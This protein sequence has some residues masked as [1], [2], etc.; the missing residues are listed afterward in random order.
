MVQLYVK[1]DTYS[2]ANA[3]L[4]WCRGCPAGTVP[5]LSR[6][7]R[8]PKEGDPD[9]ASF[10][11]GSGFPA[12]L[13]S[14]GGCGTRISPSVCCSNSPRRLARSFMRCSARPTGLLPWLC[15]H[16]SLASLGRVSSL[17]PTDL[18]PW[19]DGHPRISLHSIRATKSTCPASRSGIGLQT[20]LRGNNRAACRHMKKPRPRSTVVCF[21]TDGLP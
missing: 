20:R 5:F 18:N 9:V 4:F 6:Q 14:C 12:L 19:P 10:A 7:E 13:K 11:Y 8:Y 16:L 15:P 3:Q 1:V 17:L 21:T 2:C